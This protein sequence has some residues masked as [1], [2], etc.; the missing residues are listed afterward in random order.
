MFIRLFFV[1][2][3]FGVL[4]FSVNDKQHRTV[5]DHTEVTSFYDA[6]YKL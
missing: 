4:F 3:S 6:S 5:A 2:F 1:A